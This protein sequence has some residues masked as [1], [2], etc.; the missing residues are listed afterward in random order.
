[1]ATYQAIT[2][3]QTDAES[4][5]DTVIA[6]QW[7]NNLLAALEGDPS[8][9]KI[10]NLVDAS[11]VEPTAG[12][13]FMISA[14]FGVFGFTPSSP[15]SLVQGMTII[16]KRTGTYL[17]SFD[18]INNN[19]L[20]NADCAVF[21]NGSP[22][23][24]GPVQIGVVTNETFGVWKNSSQSLTLNAG[25]IIQLF[26]KTNNSSVGGSV[27]DFTLSSATSLFG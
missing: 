22:G 24:S 11:H 14:V 10:I 7:T 5:L 16:I 23:Y 4:Y 15:F 21:R 19:S 1:M 25:D 13:N 20:G 9:P 17:V 6:G 12:T 8:A 26:T 18:L 27:K 2:T 3:G